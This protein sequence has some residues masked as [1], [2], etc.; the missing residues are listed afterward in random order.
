MHGM[1]P[2]VLAHGPVGLSDYF[3]VL[4]IVGAV[5]VIRAAMKDPN[6]KNAANDAPEQ[7]PDRAS[8]VGRLPTNNVSFQSHAAMRRQQRKSE[9]RFIGGAR[10]ASRFGRDDGSPGD[11]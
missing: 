11:R 4:F 3:P 8:S 5:F 1:M 2:L 7:A 10:D 9:G 6:P